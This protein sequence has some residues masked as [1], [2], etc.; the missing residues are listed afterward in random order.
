MS[1]IGIRIL[2]GVGGAAVFAIIN[3]FILTLSGAPWLIALAAVFAVSFTAALIVQSMSKKQPPVP[4]PGRQT[5]GSKNV[6]GGQMN[7]DV[8]GIPKQN[9]DTSSVG[10]EN[11]SAADMNVTIKTDPRS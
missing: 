7:I 11:K 8:T 6:S 4:P 2:A 5:I 3:N 9:V 10:S 1:D